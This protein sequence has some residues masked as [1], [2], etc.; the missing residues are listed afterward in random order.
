MCSSDLKA[1]TSIA[2]PFWQQASWLLLVVLSTS[3]A[4]MGLAMLVAALARS[5]M[6]VALFGAVPVLVLALIGGCV[7]P[8]EM[9]PEKTQQ[10]TFLTPQGWALSAYRELLESSGTYEPNLAAVMLACGVLAACGA[11]FL[12]LAWGLLRLE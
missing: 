4:A 2:M 12:A 3:F 9:M 6:Q 5:E 1:A 8:R 10:M 7:L 11:A